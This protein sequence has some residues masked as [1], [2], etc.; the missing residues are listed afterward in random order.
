MSQ[1]GDGFSG[2]LR[3]D[4][5]GAA[6]RPVAI[7]T[8]RP[9]LVVQGGS[10]PFGRPSQYPPLPAEIELVEI[11][12]ASQ[13]LGTAT[14]PPSVTITL[15]TTA[16]TEWM[17]RQPSSS[18][19]TSKRGTAVSRSYFTALQ[20]LSDLALQP[21]ASGRYH[22]RF[23]RHDGHWRFAERRVHVDLAGD[24]SHHLRHAT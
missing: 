2:T 6:G 24:M 15:I 3:G 16:V 13:T 22:D 12:S 5:A 19:S 17:D 20:A 9:T 10:D 21:I 23:E 4:R 1:H 11:P 18:R 8:G 7:A 14:G